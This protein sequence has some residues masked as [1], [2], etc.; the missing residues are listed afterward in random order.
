MIPVKGRPF[1]EYVVEYLGSQGV[2][3]VILSTGYKGDQIEAHFTG[4]R[5]R[6]R[7]L[8]V[9]EAEPLGTGG[10]VANAFHAGDLRGWTLVANGDSITRFDL[11]EM[12]SRAQGGA[13]AVMLGVRVKDAGRFGTLAV[14]K[15]G[16]LSGYAEK[17]PGG[18]DATINAGIYLMQPALFPKQG[19]IRPASI[20][21]DCLPRWLREGRRI[22]VVESGGPFIDMGTPESLDRAAGFIETCGLFTS[23][24]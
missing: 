19:G 1:L 15:D 8:C 6:D 3:R 22:A 2:A 24:G 16:F 18:G 21:L 17:K 11:A 12:V 10:A 13:D 9:R 20:E 7:I 23:T 4:T 5:W 14:G